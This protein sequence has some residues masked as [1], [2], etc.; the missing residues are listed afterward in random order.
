[1][2]DGET[3][4]TD[5]DA[6]GTSPPVTAD[7]P[8]PT[9]PSGEPPRT[10]QVAAA[11][12]RKAAKAARSASK[13]ASKAATKA[14]TEIDWK[15]HFANVLAHIGNG[16]TL[17]GKGLTHL[18]KWLAHLG[19]NLARL[20]TV[21][22]SPPQRLAILGGLVALSILGALAFPG[23]A[24]GQA[25]VVVLVPGLSLTVGILGTR[26]YSGQALS[27]H[28]AQ[29]IQIAASS[30]RQLTKSVRY[31]DDRLTEAQHHLES[32]DKDGALIEVVRAKTATELSLGAA[33]QTS[34]QSEPRAGQP[35]R[36][37]GGG[38]LDGSIARVE[39]QYTVIINRGSEH[40]AKADMM[41]A[42]M[43][44]GGDQIL[45]PETGDVIGELPTE[46]LR[47]KVV[48]VQPKYSRAE[49]FRT[50]T[51]AR[52]GSP[53]L[54]GYR[55]TSGSAVPGPAD[56]G[57]FDAIDESITRMLETEL[58]E[59]IPVRES[60]AIAKS[61]KAQDAPAR[62]QVRVDIG[63]RVRQVS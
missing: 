58:A 10:A 53:A 47:V 43:A 38:V 46:K 4:P 50:F 40:G 21:R 11:R 7:I 34:P 9:T 2:A 3:F 45:D 6:S 26:W 61:A 17:L 54:T 16:I 55:L 12:G 29:A 49:T 22:P 57:A 37:H 56:V 44:D 14:A 60:I 18:G 23:N 52:F 19:R 28:A 42:V 63:D 1:M 31:V 24:F 41:F 39:D 32:G 5:P 62:P 33:D 35:L 59:P 25:C 30:A 13:A 36:E 48:D 20:S 8:A 27:Q 15:A 51:P